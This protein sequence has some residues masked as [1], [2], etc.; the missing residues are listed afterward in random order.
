MRALVEPE[1]L[2]LEDDLVV[3]QLVAEGVDAAGG[4]AQARGEAEVLEQVVAERAMRAARLDA[5]ALL[6][7]AG[8]GAAST[9]APRRGSGGR[10]LRLS[11]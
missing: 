3:E 8:D 7:L 1:G 4:G 6:A 5:A 11:R 2:D 9:R 10:R